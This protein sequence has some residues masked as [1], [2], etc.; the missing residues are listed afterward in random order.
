MLDSKLTPTTIQHTLLY[1]HV[2][3]NGLQHKQN[4]NSTKTLN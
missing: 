2:C 1:L 3:E 4:R